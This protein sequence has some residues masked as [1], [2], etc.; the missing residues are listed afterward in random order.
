[1]ISGRDALGQ[2]ERTIGAER[3]GVEEMETRLAELLA[4][5]E[6][7]RQADL[8]AFRALARLR[9]DDIA[10]GDVIGRLEQVERQAAE[11][12]SE[13]DSA[14]KGVEV[15]IGAF[16][17]ELAGLAEERDRGSTALEAAGAEIEEAETRTRAR[18]AEDPG[19]AAEA[20]R[21]R[22]LDIQAANAE[23][24]AAQSEEE[25]ASKREAY[26]TNALFDYLW[27]R[28]YG[29][30]SYAALP[31][32]RSLDRWVAGLVG[33]E[34][35]RADFS[36]LQEIPRRLREHADRL[37]AEA[38]AG[39]ARLAE[40]W[41]AARE[42]DGLGRLDDAHDAAL[43]ALDA[44]DARIEK[45]TQAR[46]ALIEERGRI[47]GGEDERT[48]AAVDLLAEE[49]RRT[50]LTRLLRDA[51][52]T[53]RT[54]DDRIVSGMVARQR[55]LG[56]LS[57]TR[58]HL[59][60]TLARHLSRMKELDEVS[61]EFKRRRYAQN[62]SIFRDGALLTLLLRDLL[63]SGLPWDRFW[64][65]IERQHGRSRPSPGGGVIPGRGGGFGLPRS[66]RRSG[67]F[68]GGAA[69]PSGGGFRT[70]GGF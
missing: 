15:R 8:E 14:L 51:R 59:K 45:A 1:M 38:D 37:V 68:G 26:E 61:R 70:G 7:L 16:D 24:K 60:E 39:E 10:K 40:V 58:A 46:H 12:L 41:R 67:G 13:R 66:S 21:A 34:D 55:E 6:R 17:A 22:T 64:R 33:Y 29:T 3:A 42:A 47:A 23:E 2:L 49:F 56:A 53:L 44:V 19:Y 9:L 4:E 11:I 43:S 5:Q 28:G 63:E 20:E 57:A 50:D 32:I 27:K 31:L 65:E 54:E 69:R 30:P 25:L 62:G 52:E 48:L 18:L 35:A 36:R